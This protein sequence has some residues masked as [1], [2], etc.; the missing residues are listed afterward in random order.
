MTGGG[1]SPSP[2]PLAAD[3]VLAPGVV[4]GL[5]LGDRAGLGRVSRSGSSLMF[6]SVP[7]RAGR[8]RPHQPQTRGRDI[9]GFVATGRA[10]LLHLPMT[11][12]PDGN[13]PSVDPPPIAPSSPSST[14][15][16]TAASANST[17]CGLIINTITPICLLSRW[18]SASRLGG[19]VLAVDGLGRREGARC[20]STTPR[21]TATAAAGRRRQARPVPRVR[22]AGPGEVQG[23]VHIIKESIHAN[24]VEGPPHTLESYAAL[25]RSIGL[26]PIHRDFHQD[27]VFAEMRVGGPNPVVLRRVDRPRRPVPRHRGAFRP[28][29]PGRDTLEAAGREGRLYLLDYRMLEGI[30]N[31]S[32]PDRQKYVYAPLCLL[33]L[34]KSRKVLMPVAIQCQQTPGPDNPIF[35]PADGSSWLIAKTVVKVA[36]GNHHEAVTHLGRT[37]L[38]VEP[39]VIATR[40][41]LAPNHP[42]SHPA[43]APLRGDPGDQQHGQG[44]P[45][46]RPGAGRRAARRHDRLDP[47]ADGQGVQNTRSTR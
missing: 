9:R 41:Q 22:R 7:I 31:S 3:L 24:V 35:T 19:A 20:W 2:G 8:A 12:A 23:L 39:F 13:H 47:A 43:R 33:V 28:G 36:D 30:E 17:S 37:H 18:S 40:R 45:G 21:S 16:R 14:P 15:T 44:L 25:F 11:R 27:R 38:F 29:D 34:H 5:L 10:V 46:R 1:S 4:V 42:L 32:F 6:V 26:P